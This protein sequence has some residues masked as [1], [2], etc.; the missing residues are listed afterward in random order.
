MVWIMGWLGCEGPEE[1]PAREEEQD[2]PGELLANP[3]GTPSCWVWIEGG[4]FEMGAR[5]G[6]RVEP[7]EEPRHTVTIPDFE[8][9]ATEVPVQT[10]QS[11]VEAGA[12]EPLPEELPSYCADQGEL[13]ARGCLDWFAADELCRWLWA[14]LPTEAEWEFAARSGGVDVRFPWGESLPSCDLAVLGYVQ[15]QPCGEDGP[16]A[17]CSRPAGQTRQGLCDMA[18]NIFEWVED[19]YHDD[20]QGAPSD[21]SAWL[22]QPTPFRVLRGGGINSDE[23]VTTWNRTFHEPDF[24]Y[25]GMGVRCAR[26]VE[27]SVTP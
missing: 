5:P 26:S 14:R 18:G 27:V 21:G 3:C 6:P 20:Y 2:P 10:H 4:S 12:C 11:C 7:D 24:S 13:D 17:V 15:G 23:P 22:E 19:W 8:L 16:A 1:G 25:S 9:M